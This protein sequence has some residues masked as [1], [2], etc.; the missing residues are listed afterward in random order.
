VFVAVS[1]LLL[2]W[3]LNTPAGLLGKAD[4]V[5]Y[6][7][8][9][10]IDVRSFHLGERQLPLCAR[11]TGMYLGAVLGLAYQQVLSRRRGGTPGRAV[12]VVLAVLVLFFIVDGFNSFISFF[13]G[14]P[15]LYQPQNGLRLLAGSGMGIAI[16]VALFP[17]FNQTVWVDLD[18]RPAMPGLRSLGRLALLMLLIDLLVYTQNPLLLYPL[19]LISAAGVLLLL[20]LAYTMVWVMIFRTE[21]KYQSV[22]QLLLPLAAGFGLALAQIILLD[23]ARYALTGTWDG[24][25]LG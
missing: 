6:A 2:G 11:C 17:A 20:T 1:L 19:A 13:P 14:A 5:G 21:N 3:L 12:I 22:G 9:H 4:A 25:H 15:L 18:A 7:V 8:C 10:R 24:F 23:V 16:A